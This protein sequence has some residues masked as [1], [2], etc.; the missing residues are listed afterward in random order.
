MIALYETLSFKE[1]N[2]SV[3]ISSNV[4]TRKRLIKEG[5][6]KIMKAGDFIRA[7]ENRVPNI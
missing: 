1:R 3:F 6:R 5:V 4:H 2:H 7:C